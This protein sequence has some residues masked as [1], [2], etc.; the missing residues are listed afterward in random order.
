MDRLGE[1]QASSGKLSVAFHQL[2]N[3]KQNWNVL[4]FYK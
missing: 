4:L 2:S 3:A 1:Q